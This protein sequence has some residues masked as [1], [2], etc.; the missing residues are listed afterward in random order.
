MVMVALLLAET[1]VMSIVLDDSLKEKILMVLGVVIASEGS[2]LVENTL[3]SRVACER[4][5]PVT[6]VVKV[7][8][9]AMKDG[10]V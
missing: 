7:S 10:V 2:V 8:P 9:T 3:K 5:T 1:P 6:E 4:L